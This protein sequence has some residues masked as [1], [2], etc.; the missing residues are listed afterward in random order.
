MEKDIGVK[1]D[2]ERSFKKKYIIGMVS[3]ILCLFAVSTHPII[4]KG[5]PA[6]ITSMLFSIYTVLFEVIMIT[7]ITLIESLILRNKRKKLNNKAS[8]DPEQ[9]FPTNSDLKFSHHAWK[10]LIIGSVFALAQYLFFIGFETSDAIT[11]S[12]ALKS[13]TIWMIILGAVF[14][15]EKP[16]KVQL[17]FTAIIFVGLMYVISRGTFNLGNV[18]IGTVILIFVTMLWAIGHSITKPMLKSHIAIPS[19]VIFL[20]TLVSSIVL[21]LIYLM[22]NP[23]SVYPTLFIILKP[24]N[25]IFG[26]MIGIAYLIGHYFWYYSIKNIDIAISSGIQTVQPIIT[27]I[28]A[29]YILGEIF[30]IY[31][32]IGLI[33]ITVCILIILVDNRK[34]KLLEINNQVD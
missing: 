19:Q 33:W 11:G 21:I 18:N 12:I 29:F 24:E 14:L 17:F 10:F 2:L 28:L 22:T 25:F 27:S 15:R 13:S 8:K 7:P 32:L 16:S 1:S 31:H 4:T 30:T 6:E 3:G 20:R 9:T 34:N 5:R 23:I 26:V